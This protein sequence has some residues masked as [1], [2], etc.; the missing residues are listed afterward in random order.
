MRRSAEALIDFNALKHNFQR[1][2]QFAPNSKVMAVIKADAY[3]HGM[4][5]CAKALHDADGFAVA[6]ISE[7]IA[8]R[9]SGIQQPI[10]VFQGFQ[11]KQQ[12]VQMQ[13]MNLRPVIY[14]SWQVEIL[15][16]QTFN[17]LSVWLKVNTG[18]NRLGVSTE[19]A[20]ELW[21]R[22]K[23]IKSIKELGL[24]SHFANADVP[25]DVSNQQ[26]IDKF[27]HLAKTFDAQTSMANSAGLISFSQ[28]QGDWVRPGIMLYGSS[29]LQN[30]TATELDLKPVMQLQ[31]RL[32]AVNH[33]KKGDAIG[34]GSLWQCPED[35]SVGVAAIGYGDGYPRHA[36][37]GT[38]V[39]I[40]GQLSQLLGRVSM[41]AISVDLRGINAQC[42]D[43]VELW[44]K[45]VSVD[46]VAKSSDTIAYELLCNAAICRTE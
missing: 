25:E 1:V 44:G 11:N 12:L 16:Q 43:P 6:A 15:E 18:M 19:E 39:S 35:M 30:K 27:N 7:A 46:E 14:Q 5:Q 40:N 45:H 41:D 24:S 13:A 21:P 31:T 26:Q 4:L 36:C 2:K 42:G 29:P 20:V 23:K 17:N 9:E 33:L 38:P 22:L 8:L 28:I 3:G 10:T 32:I 34:Y 37:T